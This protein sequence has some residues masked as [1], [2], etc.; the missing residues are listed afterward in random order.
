[1]ATDGASGTGAE[2]GGGASATSAATLS[3]FIEDASLAGRWRLDP[4]ASR[5]EFAVKHFWHLITVRGWFER[6]EGEGEAAG[7]GTVKGRVTIEAASLNTKNKQRDK[8]LRSADFFDVEQ[9]PAVIVTV[10]SAA[11]EDATH[12]ALTGTFEAAGVR[13]PVNF[14]A[15]IVEASPDAVTLRAQLVVDRTRFGMT[16]SPMG[17]AASEAA[18]TFTARL[19]K[20]AG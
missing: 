9:H 5:V 4:A 20:V 17:I 18:A 10:E 7:D 6:F 11:L 8:H 16:W 2:A 15:E 3:K 12:V 19:T 13:E 1:M 14:G